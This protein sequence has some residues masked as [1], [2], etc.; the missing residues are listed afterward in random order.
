MKVP[1]V[2]LKYSVFRSD[3]MRLDHL[4]PMLRL[5]RMRARICICIFH[6]ICLSFCTAM[7][8]LYTWMAGV[9]GRLDY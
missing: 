3:A 7:Q 9:R 8:S 2:E 6:R 5:I 1:L 4:A